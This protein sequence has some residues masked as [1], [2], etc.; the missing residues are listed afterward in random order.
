[1]SKLDSLSSLNSI[2]ASETTVN[3][4]GISGAVERVGLLKTAEYV[5]KSEVVEDVGMQ[6]AAEEVGVTV[7]WGRELGKADICGI[8]EISLLQCAS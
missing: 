5:G 4:V 7:C 2:S 1:M 6:R 8:C 3:N